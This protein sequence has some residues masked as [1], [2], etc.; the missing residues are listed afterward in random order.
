[1]R[2]LDLYQV[3]YLVLCVDIGFSEKVKQ[4]ENIFNENVALK[5]YDSFYCQLNCKDEIREVEGDFIFQKLFKRVI[6]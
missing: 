4:Y 2:I 3:R 5:Y 6:I 1:M